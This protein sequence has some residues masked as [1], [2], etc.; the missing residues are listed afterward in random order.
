VFVLVIVPVEVHPAPAA[1]R[2]R[3][4]ARWHVEDQPVTLECVWHG[5]PPHQVGLRWDQAIPEHRTAV[6]WLAEQHRAG[7]TVAL[8]VCPDKA[9]QVAGLLALNDGDEELPARTGFGL[10]IPLDCSPLTALPS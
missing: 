7:A 10:E 4:D 6:R 9:E 3:M 1:P 8:I 5:S 2:P